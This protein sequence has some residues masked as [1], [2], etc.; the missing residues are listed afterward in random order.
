MAVEQRTDFLA[1]G[2]AFLVLEQHGVE[3]GDRAR[4]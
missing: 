1:D 4:R 3:R 2:V